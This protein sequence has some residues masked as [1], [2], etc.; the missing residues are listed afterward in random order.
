METHEYVNE[1]PKPYEAPQESAECPRKSSL[2][3]SVPQT[4]TFDGLTELGVTL[5]SQLNLLAVRDD[6]SE[7]YSVLN[8]DK[9]K[10]ICTLTRHR[11]NVI[12]ITTRDGRVFKLLQSLT[13]SVIS[14]P[15]AS[16]RTSLLTPHI[17]ALQQCIWC[18]H[19]G[20]YYSTCQEFHEAIR[21]GH[22]NLSKTNRILSA[23]SGKQLPLAIG[24]GGMKAYL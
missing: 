17:N 1:D 5:D 23:Q 15:K 19:F 7:V 2:Q 9:S 21:Y 20:H 18:D 22:I 8:T 3:L 24:H 6:G 14:P 4:I 10:M 12:N 13:S 11:D 16:V